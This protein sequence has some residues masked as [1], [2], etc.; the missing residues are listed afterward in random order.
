M[1]RPRKKLRLRPDAVRTV[2]LRMPNVPGLR[3]PYDKVGRLVYFGRM[4][5][6]I[7]LHA[8]GALPADYTDN[9]GIGFDGRCCKF[10]GIRYDDLKA[11]TLTG[12]DSDEKLLAWAHE[13]GGAR[14][15]DECEVWNGFMMK[16]GW[17]DNGAETLAKRIK[18]S[19]LEGKP[20]LCMFDYL[21]FD[22][23]RDPTVGSRWLG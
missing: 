19:R 2:N 1:G 9:L 15:D 14:T 20:I 17:R 7:R 3:S 21:D 6:K 12:K 16:R 5:D 22:E 18:E 4:V 11:R 23:G 10:L 13:T 8:K